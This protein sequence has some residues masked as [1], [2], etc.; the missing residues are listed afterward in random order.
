MQNSYAETANALSA[1]F[2]EYEEYLNALEA[3]Y[4]WDDD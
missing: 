3:D 4:N 1:A 2:S